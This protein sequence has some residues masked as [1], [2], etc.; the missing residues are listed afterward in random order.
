M[1]DKKQDCTH[2]I[3]NREIDL[4]YPNIKPVLSFK[5][6]V[7][8]FAYWVNWMDE[9]NDYITCAKAT[10]AYADYL[11]NQCEFMNEGQIKIMEI[12]DIKR[13]TSKTTLA[14]ITS[15]Y[16]LN[17]TTPSFISLGALSREFYYGIIRRYISDKK[18]IY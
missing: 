18:L 11:L 17:S 14:S 13:I 9:N 6:V 8:E 10:Q 16:V 4:F 1:T 12:S 5:D 15:V 3:S 2:A 7:A